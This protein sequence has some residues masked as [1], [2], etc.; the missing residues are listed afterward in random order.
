M[1]W[2]CKDVRRIISIEIIILNTVA[3]LVS[4]PAIRVVP[5]QTSV[6]E[7]SFVSFFPAF[8]DLNTSKV[9]ETDVLKYVFFEDKG[10]EELH[11]LRPQF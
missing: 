9:Q 6:E 11:L 4:T 8:H 7:G 5:V 3:Q 2:T 10:N 1:S